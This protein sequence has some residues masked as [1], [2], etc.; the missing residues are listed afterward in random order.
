MKPIELLATVDQPPTL[1]VE[2]PGGS[3]NVTDWAAIPVLIRA[4]DD[5]GVASVGIQVGTDPA[6]LGDPIELASYKKM[7]LNQVV[8]GSIDVA[9]VLNGK[10]GTVVYKVLATD[11]K[12]QSI[13]SDLYRINITA[14]NVSAVAPAKTVVINAPILAGLDKL[15]A[16][17]IKV[18]DA[19]AKL[20][21]NLPPPP[22]PST[23]P[24]AEEAQ[25][26]TYIA[27]LTDEQRNQFS[28]VVRLLAEGRPWRRCCRS[29]MKRRPSWPRIRPRRFPSKP[30][31][32]T[33][34]PTICGRWP[35][36]RIRNSRPTPKR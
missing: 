7:L 25:E 2:R 35:K 15:L 26:K 4:F 34:W 13:Y 30:R 6:K 24:A 27:S 10:T 19:T 33:P 21:S 18:S 20:L 3:I 17:Q 29:N 36:T 8:L 5:Y 22:P 1:V 9:T 14:P 32:S 31:R 12:G 23:Q 16:V 11:S 28:E